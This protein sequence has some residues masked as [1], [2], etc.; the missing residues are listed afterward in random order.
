MPGGF[1]GSGELIRIANTDELRAELDVNESDLAKVQ[2]DQPA[3]VAPDAYP[4]RRYAARVVKLYPQINRQ[5]GTLKVEVRILE[6]DEWLRP[7]MSVRVTF[8]AGEPARGGAASA[9]AGARAAR[10][11][12]AATSRA[13]YAWVVTEGRLRRQP[14]ASAGEAGRRPRDR[15]RAGSRAARR[16]SSARPR[17]CREGQR[18]QRERPDAVSG[19]LDT[20]AVFDTVVVGAGV[21][22]L[23]IARAEALR[24]REVVILEREPRFGTATSSRNSEVIHAGHL[25]PDRHLEDAPVR[26]G[27]ARALPLLRGARRRPPPHREAAGRDRRRGAETLD[28]LIALSRANGLIG[29]D[30]L[31]PLS[32][33]EAQRLEPEVSL[34]RG[35]ALAVDRDRRPGAADA[36][37]ARRRRSSAART[38][39]ITRRSTSAAATRDGLRVRVGGERERGG[40]LP[41][42]DQRRGARR[43]RARAEDRRIRPARAPQLYYVKGS[44]FALLGPV[45]VP[46]PDL[47]DAPRRA[48]GALDDRPRRP[49]QVRSRCRVRRRR[50]TTRSTRARRR[51][52]PLGAALLA[53]ACPTARS[54][55]AMRASARSSRRPASPGATSRSTGPRSTASPGSCSSTES[56]A[57]ASPRAS[58]SR[59]SSRRCRLN[60]QP[61]EAS[62][63]RA[64][65]AT[66]AHH[67]V[68]HTLSGVG[69]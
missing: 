61:S 52:L 33:A 6:P 16:S 11:A 2:L 37:A 40:A 42:P 60:R 24:G 26:R 30:A 28:R 54:S 58:R 47:P 31:V 51:V 14:L 1:A 4:D 15:D 13:T 17:A 36:R 67:V 55:R 43:E 57:R 59:T 63:P 62:V 38:S 46:A 9:R 53:R 21:V 34:R 39:P 66:Q 19:V 5:K 45:A 49:A 25:Q 20:A 64:R 3:E 32:A 56:R 50:S 68:L 18:V 22:G 7:D 69:P 12:C 65:W 35:R 23:A 27:P 41:A 8:F 48:L 44:Y 10:G 29:D